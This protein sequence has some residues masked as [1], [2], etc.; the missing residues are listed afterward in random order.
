M[1]GAQLVLLEKAKADKEPHGEFDSACRGCC[2]AQDTFCVGTRNRVGR[3]NQQTCIDTY[4]T[5]GF[6]KLYQDADQT[7]SNGLTFCCQY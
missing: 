1:T 6:P 5:V 4:A 7:G 2:G 3:M